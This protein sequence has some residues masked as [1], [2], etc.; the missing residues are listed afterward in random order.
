MSLDHL[1]PHAAV[2]P[3]SG[4]EAMDQN[5]APRPA[6]LV[7]G[8]AMPYD[9]AWTLQRT[10]RAERAAN[11]C[12]DLLLLIEHPSV[13]TLGRTTQDRHWPGADRLSH[14]TGIPIIRL[15]HISPEELTQVANLGL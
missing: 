15:S 11:R 1:I 3:F 7:Y 5:D 8:Q 6:T 2:E 10:C 14:E 4:T 13:Y 9:E 12:R